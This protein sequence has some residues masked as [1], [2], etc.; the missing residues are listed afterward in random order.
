MGTIDQPK[1]SSPGTP[2]SDPQP[3]QPGSVQ[4]S[5]LNTTSAERPNPESPEK[6]EREEGRRT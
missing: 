5:R 6:A 1:P 4:D 2:T 3:L